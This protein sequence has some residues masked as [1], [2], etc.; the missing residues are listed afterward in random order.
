MYIYVY[1]GM[2][3][4]KNK[5]ARLGY[6]ACIFWSIEGLDGFQSHACS[7]FAQQLV[8]VN[9]VFYLAGLARLPLLCYMSTSLVIVN[10]VLVSFV[11]TYYHDHV[12][13]DSDHVCI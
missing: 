4:V 6:S 1:V 13:F 8:I 12:H 9:F 2:S 10:V 3:Y 7:I 11:R 5:R